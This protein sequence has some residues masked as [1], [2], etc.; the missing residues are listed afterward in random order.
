M[1][2]T[3]SAVSLRSTPLAIAA[4]AVVLSACRTVAPAAETLQQI[5]E[6]RFAAMV[7]QDLAALEPML[8]E[9]LNYTHS[10]GVTENKTQFLE[11]I[12]SG[13]M[14]YEALQI[15]QLDVRTYGNLALLTGRIAARVRLADQPLALV[16]R[17]T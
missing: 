13:Q 9:E 4:L 12:R 3:V 15:E 5:E 10:T 1:R 11:Q 14:R 8:A 2:T 17:Y 16:L 6:R 7:A